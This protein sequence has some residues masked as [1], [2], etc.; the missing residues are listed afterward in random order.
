VRIALFPSA[1]APA[2]QSAPVGQ[3]SAGFGELYRLSDLPVARQ[4]MHSAISTTRELKEE[5]GSHA[6]PPTQYWRMP[7]GVPFRLLPQLL[8]AFAHDGATIAQ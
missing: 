5:P 8:L 3:G 6:L 2:G 7:A 1:S 4:I